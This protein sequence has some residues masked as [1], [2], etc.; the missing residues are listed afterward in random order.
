MAGNSIRI[1]TDQVE[2]IAANL[3]NLNK[4]L[5]EEL[6]NAKT[7]LNNLTSVWSGE[8]AQETTSS[9]NEFA[10]KYFQNYEDI[11]QQYVTFLREAVA[12]GYVEVE[13]K[14]IGLADG[15]K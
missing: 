4:R 9:F 8:A 7:T 11:I 10:N 3:E 2:G 5:R 6:E 15:F 13:V 14:N 1:D 12:K